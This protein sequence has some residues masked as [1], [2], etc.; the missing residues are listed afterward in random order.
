MNSKK[1]NSPS[2]TFGIKPSKHVIISKQHMGHFVGWDS[3]GV[4]AYTYDQNH[5]SAEITK[6][7]K[8]A[9]TKDRRFEED[10]LREKKYKNS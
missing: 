10:R 5:F 4:G 3:P 9:V 8:F 1:E 2:F 6:N 7:P